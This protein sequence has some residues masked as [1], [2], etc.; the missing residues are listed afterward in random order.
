MK[1]RKWFLRIAGGFAALIVLL[2]LASAVLVSMRQR[3][4]K[5]L[6]REELARLGIAVPDKNAS[7]DPSVEAGTASR[8]GSNKGKGADPLRPA[9]P[10]SASENTSATLDS[11]AEATRTGP[12]RLARAAT[13]ADRRSFAITA[14]RGPGYSSEEG[15]SLGERV[16]A[17][18]SPIAAKCY[19]SVVWLVGSED[20]LLAFTIGQE[21]MKIGDWGTARKYLREAL[22]EYLREPLHEGYPRD[23]AYCDSICAELAWV[24]DDPQAT[25]AWLQRLS[26]SRSECCLLSALNL[27]VQT[28]S[29]EL[30]EV[31]FH[32]WSEMVGSKITA[33]WLAEKIGPTDPEIE[34]WKKRHS[35]SP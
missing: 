27:A 21:A 33:A 25:A 15:K 7:T 12:P 14:D 20:Q 34:V 8:S 32:R 29:D 1:A 28:H 18:V 4:L 6:D 19:E 35:K 11:P 23:E 31:Y 17:R 5:P 9:D 26:A 13:A 3:A 22:G 2:A 24:E 16:F 10:V 30:A